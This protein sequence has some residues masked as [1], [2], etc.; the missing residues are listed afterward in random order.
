MTKTFYI[1]IIFFL[2]VFSCKN[3]KAEDLNA[4]HLDC[5]AN[6]I[7]ND[8]EEIT[9][10]MISL[11]T[12]LQHNVNFDQK[13]SAF[14]TVKYHYYPDQ[15]LFCSYDNS[16][17]SVYY[18]ANLNIT[19]NVKNIIVN[20]EQADTFFMDA[21]KKNPLLAQVYFLDTNS[22]LRIYPYIN[23]VNYLK[24]SVNITELAPFNEIEGKPFIGDQ[25]Y[26]MS[27]PYADPYG[28]GWIVSCTE[29]LYFR[30]N[31]I[32]IVSGDITLHSLK[33]KYFTS[34]TELL[35]LTDQN[36]RLICCT[37]EASR[38]IN[39]P[40]QREFRYYKPVKETI[41]MFNTPELTTHANKSFRKAV[42]SL[43][44]GKNQE[45]FIMDSKKYTIYKS[46][47]EQTDWLLLKII[48]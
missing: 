40:A 35:L 23:V 41:F 3:E 29:P 34:N 32:G 25:A 1:S 37:K 33:N 48:N 11:T 15:V 39:I 2:V 6:N 42:N 10:S 21:V 46:Q 17:S 14:S 7:N 38:V 43:L 26:W 4:K 47:I 28:R 22:F 13:I 20:S 19:E 5:I 12:N 8:L 30:E 36:A 24:S 27:S 44:S 45:S 31:F 18:P 16:Q 9:E